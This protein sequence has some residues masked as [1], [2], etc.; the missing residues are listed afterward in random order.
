MFGNRTSGFAHHFTAGCVDSLVSPMYQVESSL[1]QEHGLNHPLFL[2][3]AT[4]RVKVP[5][6]A[7]IDNCSNT[8]RNKTLRWP[9]LNLNVKPVRSEIIKMGGMFQKE[10]FELDVFYLCRVHLRGRYP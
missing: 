9:S 10:T 8:K 1:R 5:Q 4:I 2:L 3:S 7:S 6:N